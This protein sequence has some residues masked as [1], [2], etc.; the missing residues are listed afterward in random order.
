M[1]D[2]GI[3]TSAIGP[4]SA[5]EEIERMVGKPPELED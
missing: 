4:E 2:Y 3:I 1:P 5:Q